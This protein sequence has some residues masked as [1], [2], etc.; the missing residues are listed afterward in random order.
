MLRAAGL[1]PHMLDVSAPPKELLRELAA[2]RPGIVSTYP[3]ML[4]I[5]H[6]IRLLAEL[7]QIIAELDRKIQQT[8]LQHP[9]FS[10]VKSGAS[11]SSSATELTIAAHPSSAMDAGLSSATVSLTV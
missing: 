9:D 6:L 3:G 4:A 5:A 7:R 10:I 2:L 1:R 11:I 8:A